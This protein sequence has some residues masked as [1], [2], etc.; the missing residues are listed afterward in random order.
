MSA[1]KIRFTQSERIKFCSRVGEIRARA[2]ARHG[3]M[4]L[5]YWNQYPTKVRDGVIARMDLIAK[6]ARDLDRRWRYPKAA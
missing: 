4:C 6:I 5:V 1:D 3:A 2:K